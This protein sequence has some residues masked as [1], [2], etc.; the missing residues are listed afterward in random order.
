MKSPLTTEMSFLEPS[1]VAR[2]P[3]FRLLNAQG[4]IENKSYEE[5]GMDKERALLWYKNMLTG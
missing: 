4:S 1:K 3:T 5:V 2:I